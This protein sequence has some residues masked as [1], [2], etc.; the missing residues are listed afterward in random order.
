MEEARQHPTLTKLYWLSLILWLASF[1]S[2]A[3]AFFTRIPSIGNLIV[4]LMF[5]AL[6]ARSAFHL[7]GFSI[8]RVTDNAKGRS[9][10]I[11]G[12]LWFAMTVVF[13]VFVVLYH[14]RANI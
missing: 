3:V 4:L 1:A 6:L 5:G 7:A 9:N 10:A 12:A 13:F 11:A 8:F 14:F 2:L